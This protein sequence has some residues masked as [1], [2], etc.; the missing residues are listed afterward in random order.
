MRQK[1]RSPL[2]LSNPEWEGREFWKQ[3][4]LQNPF[5]ILFENIFKMRHSSLVMKSKPSNSSVVRQP[6][7]GSFDVY[8]REI[9]AYSLLTRQEERDLA[10][11]VQEGDSAARE[12]LINANLRLVVS[13]ARRFNGLGLPLEDLIAEG[14]TGLIKAVERYRPD[15]GAALST[16]AVWWIRQSILRAIENHG[17]TI[18]LPAHVLTR[19]RRI[20]A[21][22]A[23]LTQVL[24]REP[25]DAELADHLG[26]PSETLSGTRA[27]MQ[28]PQSLDGQNSA[29]DT[30]L[31]DHLAAPAGEANDPFM[32][33]CSGCD[34]D[35]VCKI[36][37]T[38]PD[39][40][41]FVIERRYGIGGCE[42]EPLAD[43]GRSLGVTRERTRQLERRAMSFLRQA[44]YRLDP[45]DNACLLS[46]TAV[47]ER[48]RVRRRRPATAA[49]A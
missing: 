49:A 3:N 32:A 20:F 19:A 10:L 8:S 23:E 1:L 2:L 22:V 35:R 29:D 44:L 15:V 26:V 21:A 11:R 6:Y 48:A 18:R 24:G 34:S 27:A 42:P 12:H 25:D 47:P 13:Q 43:I 14:N 5:H 39:R 37:S 4:S 7:A 38:L 30:S 40:L 41:R 9:A 16:Y 31:L 36:L 46:V 17:R 28:A 45:A 33:A